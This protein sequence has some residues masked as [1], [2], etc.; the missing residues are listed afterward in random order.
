MFRLF[1]FELKKIFS[2][3]LF[4]GALIT[5]LLAN[6]FLLWY[7]NRETED[8]APLS[9][10]CLL[11]NELKSLSNEDRFLHINEYYNTSPFYKRHTQN[12]PR[13]KYLEK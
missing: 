4:I 6:T 7:T 8:R 5:I 10:Y 9:S 11:S 13:K 1:P 2:N 3:K 12:Y